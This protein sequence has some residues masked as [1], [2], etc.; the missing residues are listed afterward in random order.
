MTQKLKLAVFVVVPFVFLAGCMMPTP[1]SEIT[2]SDTSGLKYEN[3]DCSGLSA[4]LDFLVRRENLFVIAQEQRIKRSKGWWSFKG[5]D[6]IE[7]AELANVRGEKESV[8]SAMEVRG[9]K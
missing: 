6:G 7:A 8:R 3:F 2:G 4:K 1:T 5:G 9:C